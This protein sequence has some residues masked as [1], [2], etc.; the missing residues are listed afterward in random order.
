MRYVAAGDQAEL[1]RI[2]RAVIAFLQSQRVPRLIL[3]GRVEL[4]RVE[5]VAFFLKKTNVGTDSSQS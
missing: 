3:S 4:P 2:M 5:K 1:I